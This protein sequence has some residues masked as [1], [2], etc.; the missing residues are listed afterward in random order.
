MAQAFFPDCEIPA[1][2]KSIPKTPTLLACNFFLLF[3]IS[4]NAV[5]FWGAHF[6]LLTAFD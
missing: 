6:P 2:M 3:I 1:S 5:T 4:N